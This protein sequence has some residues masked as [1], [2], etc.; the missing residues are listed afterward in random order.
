MGCYLQEYR[1]RIGAWAARFSSCGAPAPS[2][3]LTGNGAA[4]G[5]AALCATTNAV[6][7]LIG[8]VEPNPGPEVEVNAIRILCSGCNNNLKSGKQCELC[9]LWYHASCG[10]NGDM[11]NGKWF[12]SKCRESRVR[13]LEATLLQIQELE[14]NAS[15]EEKLRAATVG[16]AAQPIVQAPTARKPILVI[17]DSIVRH[18]G[19]VN[20]HMNVA[21]LPGIRTE[22]LRRY[23]GNRDLGTPDTVII[24]V[25]TNDLRRRNPDFVMGDMGDLVMKAQEKFPKA[26]IYIS[27]ILR[28]RGI[29]WRRV[30]VVNRMYEWVAQRRNVFFVDPNSWLQDGDFGRDGLHLNRSGSTKLGGLFSR[31]GGPKLPATGS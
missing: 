4:A 6:L 19:N 10:K 7:L 14:L 21:C 12:C 31:I 3:S 8:G 23:V 20:K 22:Q 24:H 5:A 11:D 9:G 1:A 27:G 13:Q 2:A 16:D 28:R 30:D 15:L 29:P 26:K 25:G 17:G 18:E